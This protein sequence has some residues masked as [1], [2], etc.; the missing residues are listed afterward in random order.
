MATVIRLQRGGR[1]HAPY[2][3][4]VV[5]DSR[6]RTKG[7]VLDM[8]GTYHPCARPEPRVEVDQEKTLDWLSKGVRLSDTVRSILSAKG[9]LD[10]SGAGKA[11]QVEKG[12]PASSPAGDAE[13]TPAEA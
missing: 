8:I 11:N 7:R 12:E 6:G 9:L 3:R 10:T 13:D 4:V 2:Y 1:K 5:M